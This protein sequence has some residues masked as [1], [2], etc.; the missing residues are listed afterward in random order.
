MNEL[1]QAVIYAR[2]SCDKQTEQSI[3]G[4]LRVIT[5]FAAKNGFFIKTSYIDR[6]KS[7]KTANRP[8]FLRMISDSSKGLFTHVLVYKL[9][10]FSRN[11]YDSAFYKHKLK[12]HGVQVISATE[13][14]SDNPESI[15]TEAMLEAMAEFYSAELG[16]KTKRGMRE[17]ALKCQSTGAPPPLGY[18]WG[19]DKK[20]CIDDATAPITKLVFSMYADGK[21]KKSIAKCLNDRG[22]R[23]RSGGLFT[24]TSFDNMLKNKKYIGIYTYNDIEIENGCPAL[25][26]A[27]TF[28]KVQEMIE[29]TKKAPARA[30]AKTEYYLA[31]RVFCGHCGS[32]MNATGGTGREGK[33]YH[34]Y[35]CKNTE[36]EKK[37]ESKDFI[38]WFICDEIIAALGK[39]SDRIADIIIESYKKDMQADKVSELERELQAVERKLNGVVDMLLERK[40]DTLL[41][42]MDELELQKSEIEEELFSAKIA[43]KHIPSKSEIKAWLSALQATDEEGKANIKQ[44]LKTFVQKVYL[45]NDKAVI[46]FSFGDQTEINLEDIKKTLPEDSESVSYNSDIGSPL[47]ELK[48]TIIMI[49]KKCVCT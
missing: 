36:C 33:Q 40:T 19:T 5:D 42:K 46:V 23:T 11:R 12:Q 3:D 21:G 10:R 9:D 35:K 13:C 37:A 49:S 29:K 4:Q 43:E 31:G 6:A 47:C 28:G 14:L 34:Y 32:Q 30:R 48:E 44:I 1:K 20:L 17:S 26:D 18:K 25:I 41:K 15:I 39:D 22:Y 45:W 38:E 8:E 2:Y 16:Q 24:H 27:E 7:A